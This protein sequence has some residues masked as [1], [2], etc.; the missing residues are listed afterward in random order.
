MEE[1]LLQEAILLLQTGALRSLSPLV[2]LHVA[3][4]ARTSTFSPSQ[5]SGTRRKRRWKSSSPDLLVQL[6]DLLRQ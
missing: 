5:Q 2:L 3:E 4:S 6:L 1:G